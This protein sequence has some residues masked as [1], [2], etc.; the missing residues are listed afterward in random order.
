M[1]K[2]DFFYLGTNQITHRLSIDCEEGE[3]IVLCKVKNHADL[4]KTITLSLTKQS[5]Y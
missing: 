5:E 4:D 1:F 2:V 3:K